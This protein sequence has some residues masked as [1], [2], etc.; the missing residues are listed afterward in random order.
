MLLRRVPKS[1][2][3][4]KASIN[5]GS[6]AAYRTQGPEVDTQELLLFC[7]QWLATNAPTLIQLLGA[8]A[9]VMA[10]GVV[11]YALHVTHK[12]GGRN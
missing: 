12:R 2:Q 10:L 9:P 8:L 4:A 3:Y 6:S 11:G 1:R 5:S 7:L